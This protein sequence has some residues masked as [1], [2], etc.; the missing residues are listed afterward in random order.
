M[1]K[2]LIGASL[3]VIGA[4]A[5]SGVAYAGV[6]Q[7]TTL[8]ATVSPA[9]QSKK[10]FGPATIHN[11]IATTYSDFNATPGPKETIFKIDKDVTLA[12]GSR[13]GCS[14]TTLQ[15]STSTTA[16]NAACQKSVV[17]TGT[18]TVNNGTTP[19]F[20][21]TNPVLLVQGSKTTLYVWTRIGGAQT[22]VLVGQYRKGPNTLD[23]TGLPNVAGVDLTNFDTTFL[24]QGKNSYVKA[25]CSKGKWTSS[26]TQTYNT[27][28]TGSMPPPTS[29]TS[30][31][32]CKGK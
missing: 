23:V 6:P 18:N 13:P 14:L 7:V 9:K 28:P 22:L 21:G 5:V 3:G 12:N 19:L 31:Q 32:K 24:K 30:K 26:V 4:L 15:A 25:R 2:H 1:R 8:N 29:A 17:G 27:S 10:T 16:V 11:I 20:P